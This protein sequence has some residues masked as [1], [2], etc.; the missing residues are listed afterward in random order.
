VRGDFPLLSRRRVVYLDSAAT[1]QKPMQ[2]LDAMQRFYQLKNANVHRGVYRL[3]EEADEELEG[4]RNAVRRFIG[5]PAPASVIFTRGTT[6]SINLVARGWAE[7]RLRAG[8]E[9]LITELEHHSNLL[10]WQRVAARTGAVLRLAPVEPSGGLDVGA[11]EGMVGPRTRLIAF[12]L[13]SNVL[14]TEL[15]AQR[16]VQAARKVG[17]AVLIDAAQAAPHQVIDVGAL[18]CDFLA[19]SGHKMLGPTG[20]GVLW[21][22]PDRLD[23]VEPLLLGGGMVR[24]VFAGSATFLDPPWKFEAG[25]P[26]IAE[27]VGLHAAISYLEALR[28]D[29][30]QAHA[31]GLAAYAEVRLRDLAGVTL[32]A[33][34]RNRVAVLS[35]NLDGVHPH[36]AAAFLDQ[37]GICVRAGH[38]CAQP[39][40][41]RL[42]VAGTIRASVQVY[43]T[44]EEIDALAGA[45]EEARGALC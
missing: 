15:P 28:M 33:P 39:L 11:L 16:I 42:G 4:A 21:V 1:S 9:I 8:D 34:G 6:E 17:A 41:R 27:A 29:E 26:P 20:I 31:R 19:F 25:T 40:M 18:G 22:S 13:V 7:H 10:P 30:V 24:E 44:R 38:H 36:D 43:S 12:S 35:F 37:R 5:A 14:G 23:E 2:V 45:L 32:Y 3:A